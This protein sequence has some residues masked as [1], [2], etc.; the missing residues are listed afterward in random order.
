RAE[1]PRAAPAG[2]VRRRRANGLWSGRPGGAGSRHRRWAEAPGALPGR[3]TRR[4]ATRRRPHR[5]TRMTRAI[6]QEV[7]M[8]RWTMLATAVLSVFVAGVVFAETCLST[9]AKTLRAAGKVVG[10]WTL[11]VQAGPA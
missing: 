9:Y 7:S 6:Q 3:R 4:R 11:P 5:A 8:K 1:R 10:L 2:S